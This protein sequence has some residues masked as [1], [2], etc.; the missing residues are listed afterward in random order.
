MR[1]HVSFFVALQEDRYVLVKLDPAGANSRSFARPTEG[2]ETFAQEF[3]KVLAEWG[4]GR[5]EACLGLPSEMVMAAPVDC[6]GIS[7]KHRASAMLYRLEEQLPLEAERL[8]AGFLPV[9]GNRSLGLAVQTASVKAVVEELERA[10]VKIASI[11][12]TAILAA[13]ELE[14]S[15][16]E[17]DF[18]VMGGQN[19]ADIVRLAQ[20]QVIS[21][22]TAP[23]ETAQVADCLKADIIASPMD[24]ERPLVLLAGKSARELSGI[25]DQAG[26]VIQ[27]SAQDDVETCAARAASRVLSGQMSHIADFRKGDLAAPGA[28]GRLAKQLRW[29]AA[30][31]ATLVLAM[32]AAFVVRGLQYD[33][34]GRQYLRDQ[35][36]QYARL[37]PNSAVP[38]SVASRLKSELTRL[39][40][41]SGL[42]EDVPDQPSALETLRMIASA[43]PTNLRMRLTEVR[44]GP[45]EVLIEGQART[46]SDAE[47]FAQALK[48]KGFAIDPPRTESLPHQGVGFTLVA[49]PGT[50]KVTQGGG[51]L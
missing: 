29:S 5:Q 27:N 23:L 20:G 9:V 47:V 19:H 30:L 50:D 16:P 31:A 4:C 10:G 3:E 42:G 36:S 17:A 22:H 44:I 37:Y 18:I 40:G 48:K 15:N 24:K 8:T 7:K 2:S 46:H 28:W 1:N 39:S 25:A 13:Q 14:S 41:T 43:L 35:V 11:C 12:P 6:S 32:I 33:Q 34:L 26:V 45:T 21:W 38:P 49:K 51:K